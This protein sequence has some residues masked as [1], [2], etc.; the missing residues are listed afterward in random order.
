MKKAGAEAHAFPLDPF[1]PFQ[2]DPARA[3]DGS[4]PIL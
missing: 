3:A 2:I 1:G 4:G